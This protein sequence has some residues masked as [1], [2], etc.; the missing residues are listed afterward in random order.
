MKPRN[1]PNLASSPKDQAITTFFTWKNFH[2]F[3]RLP[4]ELRLKIWQRAT[5]EQRFVIIDLGG[6]EDSKAELRSSSPPPTI[7]H[8]CIGS[9]K[10]GLQYYSLS[11]GGPTKAARIYFNF[12]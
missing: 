3:S 11:F 5:E 6:P 10:V 12:D 8:A 9:R 7:L 4:K 2:F 1:Q